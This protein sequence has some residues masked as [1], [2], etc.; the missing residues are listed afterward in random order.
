M[1]WRRWSEMEA[2]TLL[3]L[4]TGMPGAGKSTVLSVIAEQGY[5]VLLMGDVVREEV[6][7]LGL[8]PTPENVGRVAVELRRK[9][10]ASA[11][12]KRCILKLRQLRAKSRII[13]VDGVRSLEEV[14]AFREE[15]LNILLVAVHASPQTRFQR[16]LARNRSD[17][18]ESWAVFRERDLRE[19]GFGIGGAIAMADYMIVNESSVEDLEAE[20]RKFLRERLGRW[21]GLR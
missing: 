17:D 11:V 16:F 5:P 3:L 12:A 15:F 14:E 20:A 8:S 18:P 1:G 13:V 4:I 19:L 2:E 6:E 21:S 9:E 10:G 7:R